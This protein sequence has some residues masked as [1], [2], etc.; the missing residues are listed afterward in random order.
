[1]D[2][3]QWTCAHC[4]RTITPGDTIV[5][6]GGSLSHWD[7]QQHRVKESRQLR[8]TSDVL[9]REAEAALH[10]LRQALRQPPPKRT[11]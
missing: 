7:C 6:G 8:G 5:F 2:H 3:Q 1:M 9:L 11:K 10:A 4:S